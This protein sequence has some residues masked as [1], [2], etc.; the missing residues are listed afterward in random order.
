MGAERLFIYACFLKRSL[1]LIAILKLA[2]PICIWATKT[3]DE[4]IHANEALQLDTTESKIICCVFFPLKPQI[5]QSQIYANGII[6]IPNMWGGIESSSMGGDLERHCSKC[7][8]YKLV[9][10]NILGANHNNCKPKV[11]NFKP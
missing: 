1:I 9:L 6:V 10:N 2:L 11:A 7:I 3:Q 4:T 5:R 8:D